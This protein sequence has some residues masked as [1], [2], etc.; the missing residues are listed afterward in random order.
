MRAL[1]RFRESKCL[2]HNFGDTYT[3]KH[4]SHAQTVALVSVGQVGKDL[5]C[6]RNCDSALVS[7][8]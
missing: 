1:V 5:G 3:G 2:H 7:D 4:G 8:F 6:G